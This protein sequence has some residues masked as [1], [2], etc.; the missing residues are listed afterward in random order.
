MDKIRGLLVACL[1]LPVSSTAQN[2]QPGD[3]VFVW[4]VPPFFGFEQDFVDWYSADGTFRRHI[5]SFTDGRPSALMFGADSV[6]MRRNRCESE[7]VLV[8]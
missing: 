5:A 7:N 6:C 3:V 2:F 1:L 8:A 4:S